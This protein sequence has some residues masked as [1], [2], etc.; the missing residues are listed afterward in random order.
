M[1]TA[2]QSL[3]ALMQE[4]ESLFR[5]HRLETQQDYDLEATVAYRMADLV[6]DVR[7][8]AKA[9]GDDYAVMQMAEALDYFKEQ[10]EREK[11]R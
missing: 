2:A 7:G 9:G 10:I 6:N 11:V 1:T 3:K 8:Y 4:F 5:Q